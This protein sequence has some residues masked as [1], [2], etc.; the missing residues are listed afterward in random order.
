M[1]RQVT[2]EEKKKQE[3][4]FPKLMQFKDTRGIILVTSKYKATMLV[5]GPTSV[6]A[7]GEA[8]EGFDWDA[9]SDY[10]EPLILENC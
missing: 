2:K 5:P 8:L 6:Y 9:L 4:S 3:I 7:A 10:E 1:I